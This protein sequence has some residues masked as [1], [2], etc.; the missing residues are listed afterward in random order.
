MRRRHAFALKQVAVIGYFV[1]DFLPGTEIAPA[2][3]FIGEE[4]MRIDGILEIPH[5]MRIGFEGLTLFKM[6]RLPFEASAVIEHKR[7]PLS[8]SY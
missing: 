4:V 6:A 8:L 5:R 2:E 7:H 1:Y 3:M